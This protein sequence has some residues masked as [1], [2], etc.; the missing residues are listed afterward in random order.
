MAQIDQDR[1]DFVEAVVELAGV[2]SV[3]LLALGVRRIGGDAAGLIAG[4]LLATNYVYVMYDRAAIMEG[5]MTA[6]IVASWYCSAQARD[7]SWWGAAAGVCAVLAY[8]TKAAAAFYV[9]A[10][11]L[12][13]VWALWETRPVRFPSRVG[14]CLAATAAAASIG[15]PSWRNVSNGW[16]PRVMV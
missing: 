5:L 7:R 6:F 2:A 12:A 4:A 13:A 3:V 9:G 10:L 1:T 14:A 15:R 11:G 8:F 16:A